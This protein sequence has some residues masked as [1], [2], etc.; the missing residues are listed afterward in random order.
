MVE[1]G[2]EKKS[3]ERGV[4]FYFWGEQC[5]WKPWM[6]EQAR[7]VA[8]ELEVPLQEIDLD[9]KPQLAEEKRIFFPGTVE[10]MGFKI[11]YPGTAEQM[12]LAFERKG[13]L[14]GNLRVR[15]LP[16]GAP[17]RIEKLGENLQQTARF[18]AAGENSEARQKKKD[19]LEKRIPP[20][21]KAPGYVAF[22]GQKP[23]GVVEFVQGKK[24]PYPLP[25]KG[26]DDLFI[27]CIYG[28]S[29]V[30]IDY[31]GYLI[32]FLAQQARAFGYGSLSVVAGEKTPHPNG[33]VQLFQEKGFGSMLFLERI[34]LKKTWE[35]IFF[36]QRKL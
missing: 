29:E 20:G 34:L 27:T 14:P 26:E 33:P 8:R 36:M 13:P 16:A 5:L 30:G 11:P 21:L 4:N 18:C 2:D 12:L 23:V 15:K 17:E 3:L 28:S 1:N 19:W 9:P 7:M 22:N 35:N 24:C 10:I 31:R 32:E 25:K 6:G